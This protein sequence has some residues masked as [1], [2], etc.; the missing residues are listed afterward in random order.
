VSNEL[1]ETA[2]IHTGR[3]VMCLLLCFAEQE[4][5]SLKKADMN[6]TWF[7]LSSSSYEN[8]WNQWLHNIDGIASEDLPLFK[9]HNHIMFCFT[10]TILA[11]AILRV[12]G[13]RFWSKY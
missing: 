5:V 9:N 12:Y 13:F 2:V 4:F 8:Y 10:S 1:V 3:F 11:V 6:Y 7:A